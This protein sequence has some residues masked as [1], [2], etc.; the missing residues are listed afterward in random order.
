[1]SELRITGVTVS[2]DFGDKSYGNGIK[3]FFSVSSKVPEAS[4]G[5]PLHCSDE[6]MNDGI[7]LYLIAWQGLL[8][9]RY[10]SGEISAAEY[11]VKTAGFLARIDSIKRLYQTIKGKT[12]EELHAFLAK[13]ENPAP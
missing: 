13:V 2:V 10:A 1:M 7:D 4:P 8:Q 6:V 12:N 11:K 9:S 3:S 5:I